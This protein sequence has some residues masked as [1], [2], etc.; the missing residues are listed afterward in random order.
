MGRN[1]T[2]D[3]IIRILYIENEDSVRVFYARQMDK[4]KV[5]S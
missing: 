4:L 2:R 3:K 5:R 1:S